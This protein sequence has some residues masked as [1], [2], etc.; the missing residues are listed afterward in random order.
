MVSKLRFSE[1]IFVRKKY[2]P[3]I[4][5]TFKISY[6]TDSNNEESYQEAIKFKENRTKL[7]VD[8]SHATQ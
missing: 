5:K 4:N 6:L 2:F 8:R 1:K 7:T 3:K